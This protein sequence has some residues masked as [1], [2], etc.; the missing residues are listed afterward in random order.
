VLANGIGPEDEVITSP[1]SFIAT[2]NCVLYAR[3]K[4]VF[5]DID[6]KT[7]NL[8]P[9]QI[10]AKIT[11]QTKAIIPV[12]LY[13]CPADM[14]AIMEIAD[15]YGLR[16]IEDA[17]QALGA[18]IDGRQTGTYGT[19][20]YS[21]YATK[22]VTMGEGG[23]ILTNDEEIADKCRLLRN[24]GMRVRYSHESLGYNLRTTD[25]HA[26]IGLVQLGRLEEFT[27][28]RIANAAYLSRNLP[29]HLTP[30]TP[31]GY[32]HVFHQFTVRVPENRDEV[33]QLLKD[34]GVGTGIHYPIPIHKQPLYQDL[35]YRDFLPVAEQAA[36]EVM[37]IP[38]NPGLTPGQLEFVAATVN[39]YLPAWQGPAASEP[40]NRREPAPDMISPVHPQ[41]TGDNVM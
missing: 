14:T 26:A 6:P 35:G 37:S 41:V 11:K 10:E 23:A 16:V 22:N 25:L 9:N 3:G 1:F 33:V 20:C 13:G 17:C 31:P 18:S 8:D 29:A 30:R 39:K 36:R 5:A 12:H 7:F 38:V 40:E 21:F 34:D 2:A 27:E 4:P 28:K 19:A 32:R 24:H 15:T